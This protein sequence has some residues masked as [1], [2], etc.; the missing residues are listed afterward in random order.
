MSGAEPTKQQVFMRGARFA[1]LLMQVQRDTYHL[2]NPKRLMHGPRAKEAL[3]E[4][5]ELFS[6]LVEQ[7]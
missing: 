6:D 2:S 7:A 3:A 5:D 4:I 1:Y